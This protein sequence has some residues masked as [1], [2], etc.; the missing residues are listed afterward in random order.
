MPEKQVIS[1]TLDNKRG[2]ILFRKRLIAQQLTN[3][4]NLEHEFDEAALHQLLRERM[5]KTL[6]DMQQLSH[7]GLRLAPFLEIGAERGQRS[8]VM[9]NDLGLQGFAAD[10]S[11]D[12]LASCS[13]F[14][15]VFHK[16]DLPWRICCD[17][18][19]LPFRSGSIPFVFCYE[20]LHHFPALSS[21]IQEIERVLTPGGTFF[22]EEEPYRKVFRFRVFRG[23]ALYSA[24]SRNRSWLRRVLDGFFSIQ[25]CNERQF[26]II[27][28]H[29]IPLREWR[30]ALSRF[31]RRQ[32]ELRGLKLR[33]PLDGRRNPFLYFLVYFFGGGIA[34]VC[35]K[36]GC[37]EPISSI[38]LEQAL[39][40]PDCRLHGQ[41]QSLLR[42]PGGFSCAHCR[43]GFPVSN[44]VLFLLPSALR[45]TL[46]PEITISSC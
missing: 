16:S 42:K 25:P 32:V 46:Y 15:R 3:Q 36:A 28:N 8:L 41:D 24:S 22:F 10:I 35:T 5:A 38:D 1:Q 9:R 17:V 26:G 37:Q 45:H 2:E 30:N 19:T 20:T 6:S 39:A 40:C 7:S 13:H 14:A 44:G 27:E 29:D 43:T 4:G 11:Y 31:S 34:G 33:S 18:N 23:P 21:V 12:M